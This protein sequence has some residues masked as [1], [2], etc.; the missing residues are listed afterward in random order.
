MPQRV[1]AVFL[2]FGAALAPIR[3]QPPAGPASQAAPLVIPA[4]RHDMS[5]PLRETSAAAIAPGPSRQI[6]EPGP[7]RRGRGPRGRRVDTIVQ[8]Y[9][10]A[11]LIPL[12]SQNFEGINNV[13]GVL[14]PDTNGDV[15]PNHYVQWVNLSLAIWSK[16]SASTPPT[17]VYGPV[18]G[19]TLWRG[20]GGPCEAD[21]NGDPIVIYDHLA[22]RWFMSQLALPNIFFGFLFGPFYQCIAV[23]ATP[24]PAGA[25]YRYQ[26]SFSKLNDYAKFGLWPDGYYMAINQFQALSLQWAGQGVAAIDREH[27]LNG[28]PASIV[29]FDLASVDINLGG[30]LPSHLAG[31]A[32]PAGSPNYFVQMDDDAWG[33]APD[34]LQLWQFHVD[35][36]HPS[37]STFT[38]A[39]QLPTEPFD[40][41][42]CGHA[43]NC[44]P[45]PATDVKVDALSDRLMYRLQ[46]H[47]FGD[48]ESLVVNHTVDVD[49]LDHAG[50]RWYEIRSPRNAP[51]IVQQGTYA[52]DLDHRWMGSVAMDRIGNMALGFSVSGPA[53]SPSIR[54]TGRL[55]DDPPGLMTQGE[56]DIMVGAGS[57]LHSSGRW[58]DYSLLAVDPV[59]QCTFWYTQEY[60]A[61]TSE[62][63]WRTRVGSFAFPSCAASADMARVT[64]A[65]PA[66]KATEA[67]AVAKSFTVTRT[68]DL[69]AP[70]DIHYEISGSA[71]PGSDYVPIPNT[72]TIAPGAATATVDVTPIDYLLIESD[73]NVVLTIGWS[74]DYIV[75]TPSSASITIASDDVPPDLIVSALTVPSVA[76]AG[77][78]ISLNDT[79]RN[80][81]GGPSDASVTSFYLSLN[82]VIDAPDYPLGTRAV[83][84]LA[85]NTS[86]AA[87]TTLAVPA[88]TPIGSYYVLAK[89]DGSNTI[90]E[91]QE[92]NNVRIAGPVRVGPDLTMSSLAAPAVVGDG[93]TVSVSDTTSN[94]GGADAGPSRTAFY[95][96]TNTGLD[97]TEQ[98]IGGRDVGPVPVGA[99]SASSA[100]PVVIP[101]GTIAGV[102]YILAKADQNNTVIESQESNN[103]RASG[104]IKIGPDLI[105]SGLNAPATAGPGGTITVTD[106]T[107]NQGAGTAAAA[108]T[109]AFYLS[110]NTLLDA[111][112]IPLGSRPVQALGAGQAEMLS[113][114][115]V[116][117]ENTA[118]GSWVVLAKADANNQVVESVETNN[119]AY[120][121]IKIGPDLT[122]TSISVTG[123]AVAGGT[124][125]VTETTKN[126]GGGAAGA[127]TTR[128]YLSTNGVFDASDQLI[129]SRDIPGIA[130]G[131]SSTGSTTCT[132]P[133]GTAPGTW[134]IIGVA[135]GGNTVVETVEW[136]NSA[137]AAFRIS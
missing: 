123:T 26:Y 41:D 56:A 49:G 4:M 3:A 92:G 36:A 133:P 127:S 117:P 136:N 69:T 20:F 5:A 88:N 1:L 10:S 30:M 9:P 82:T 137:A 131:A 104:P 86:S 111:A 23:S 128:F 13:D 38:R 70:L 67:G 73:E 115:L 119:L 47:N 85:A 19:S 40:S 134:F 2:L 62:A 118:T 79:T 31:P 51:T 94:V 29:Y 129:G 106:T 44:I 125:T 60:Y 81:G 59:D 89:A 18:P 113:T 21:N 100:T 24:D 121:G 45:Q 124:I 6:K 35:W 7:L 61:A 37:G 107:K 108:S 65:A 74:A 54:Y 52:P 22:D 42:L 112:D 114:P 87:L 34:Q 64:I 68:G 25:Y 91:T 101:A 12:P 99:S 97:A 43:E 17:L 28:Q 77:L 72:V 76:G 120:I 50:I 33:Y 39:P 48:H 80:Q 71:T 122:E 55:A 103:V 90:A 11:P 78:P 96:S 63:D 46:Y 102:Y 53:T 132:I 14:P 27:M 15:G 16:G 135:D 83:P 93:A 98:L 8:D 66:A 32:P 75:G 126:L 84:A 58:G 95:L 57:Q 130:G 105:V 116:I 110:T 109:T